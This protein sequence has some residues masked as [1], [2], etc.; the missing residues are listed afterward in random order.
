MV[1]ATLAGSAP[2]R[3]SPR[4]DDNGPGPGSGLAL[5]LVLVLVGLAA[6]VVLLTSLLGGAAHRSCSALRAL[7]EPLLHV[8]H[9]LPPLA[10]GTIALMPPAFL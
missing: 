2:A 10:P 7:L 4:G 5:L 3:L 1:A 6:G 8:A 9:E